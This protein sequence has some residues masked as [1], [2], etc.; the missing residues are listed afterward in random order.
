MADRN[1]IARPY[2]K[3]AFRHAQAAAQLARWSSVLQRGALTVTDPRVAPLLSSPKATSEQLAQLVIGVATAGIDSSDTSIE[4]FLRTL[5][6]NRR[7]G[8]LPEIAALFDALKDEAEGTV[9]VTVTS[10]AELPPAQ[11]GELTRALETRFGRKVRVELEV[12]PK[13]VGGAVVRAGDLVI[14]GSLK[15]RLERLA[16]ELTV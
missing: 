6:A 8:L 10:A 3:A 9:D 11:A 2:A 4:N 1:T 14:D 16:Y 13:L 5:A 12:D 7:L 15:S